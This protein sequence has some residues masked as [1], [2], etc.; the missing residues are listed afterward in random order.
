MTLYWNNCF[1]KEEAKNS[2]AAVHRGLPKDEKKP[3]I[4]DGNRFH[5]IFTRLIFGKFGTGD[6]E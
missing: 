3:Q 6:S 1:E 4:C 2:E 5:E